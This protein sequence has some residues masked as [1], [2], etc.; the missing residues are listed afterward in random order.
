MAQD[1]DLLARQ[2]QR[3]PSSRSSRSTGCLLQST[4]PAGAPGSMAGGPRSVGSR[5]GTYPWLAPTPNIMAIIAKMMADFPN[6]SAPMMYAM[7]PRKAPRGAGGVGVG[8]G[9]GA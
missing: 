9:A 3:T 5:P 6:L 2:L 4:A 7:I 1:L 8:G